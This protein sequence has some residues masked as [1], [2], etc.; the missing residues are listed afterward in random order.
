MKMNNI[1]IQTPNGKVEITFKEFLRS[2]FISVTVNYDSFNKRNWQ[3]ECQEIPVLIDELKRGFHSL[4]EL[5]NPVD[6]FEYA[7]AFNAD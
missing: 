1:Q 6:D 7:T 2:Q 5:K 3:I 4:W